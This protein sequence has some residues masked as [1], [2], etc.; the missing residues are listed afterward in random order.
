MKKE[1]EHSTSGSGSS[2]LWRDKGHRRGHDPVA[3]EGTNAGAGREGI[4][5]KCHNCGKAG[6]CARDC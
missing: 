6:H 4:D 3:R 5:D 1:Q 2:S